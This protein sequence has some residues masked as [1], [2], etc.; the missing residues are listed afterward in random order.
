MNKSPKIA[1]ETPKLIPSD[2]KFEGFLVP[3]IYRNQSLYKSHS[4]FRLSFFLGILL[5]ATITTCTVQWLSAQTATEINLKTQAI[6]T[7]ESLRIQSQ[8]NTYR[9]T[10]EKFKE[11]ESLRRQLRI[12]LSPV[13]DAIEKTI[14]PELSINRISVTCTPIASSPSLRRKMQVQ[15]EVFIP[16]GMSEDN[17]IVGAWPA[18]LSEFLFNHKILVTESIFSLPKEYKQMSEDKKK[19]KLSQMVGNTK[20]LNI[21]MELNPE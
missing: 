7:E 6:E 1:K 15:I 12:P 16:L 13:L 20:E 4:V 10:K 17:A 19:R 21:T 2:I 11:L 5:L 8:S 18:A 14:P 9:P 3:R